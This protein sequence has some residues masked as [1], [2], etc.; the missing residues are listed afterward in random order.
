LSSSVFLGEGFSS[1][2]GG[3]EKMPVKSLNNLLIRFIILQEVLIGKQESHHY[4]YVTTC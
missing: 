1:G 3:E 4:I 2:F